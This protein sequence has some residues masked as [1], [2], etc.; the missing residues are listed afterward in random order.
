MWN[1]IACFTKSQGILPLS[2]GFTK[3]NSILFLSQDFIKS[4][5][6]LIPFPGFHQIIHYIISLLGFIKSYS[7]LFL[8]HGF[9]KSKY[10]NSFPRVLPNP[11]TKTSPTIYKTWKQVTKRH[12]MFP[13]KNS[14]H[15]LASFN[16]NNACFWLSSQNS[17]KCHTPGRR[18]CTIQIIKIKPMY[19]SHR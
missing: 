19:K 14:S 16:K 8:S 10:I 6:I 1:H 5:R 13:H 2:Q 3:L 9:T 11:S 17:F 7:I 4:Y 12:M 18:C 15:F